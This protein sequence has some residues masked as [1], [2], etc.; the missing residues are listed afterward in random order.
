MAVCWHLY[1]ASDCVD[2]PAEDELSGVP[3]AVAFEEFLEGDGLLAERFVW[4]RLGQDVVHGVEE[5][6]P[7]DLASV[8]RALYGTD[9]IVHEDVDVG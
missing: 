2:D 8:W 1:G 5:D 7:Y 4:V 9:K 3:V 6:S